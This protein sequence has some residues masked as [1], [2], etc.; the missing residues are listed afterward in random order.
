MISPTTVTD[1]GYHYDGICP[2]PYEVAARE[3]AAAQAALRRANDRLSELASEAASTALDDDRTDEFR[4]R[5]ETQEAAYTRAR[6]AI[7][8]AGASPTDYV[9][10]LA[11]A[12]AEAERRG[13]ERE[14]ARYAD[15]MTALAGLMCGADWNDGTHAQSHGYRAAVMRAYAAICAPAEGE[16]P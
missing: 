6:Y 2:L 15:L 5:A 11:R 3:A 12:L 9:D 14:R 1:F 4:R 8:F 16:T 13:M 10:A 7:A